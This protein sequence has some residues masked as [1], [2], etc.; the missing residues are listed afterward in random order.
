MGPAL[1][2][3]S[4]YRKPFNVYQCTLPWDFCSVLATNFKN[5]MILS[6]EIL[7]ETILHTDNYGSHEE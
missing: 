3:V 6:L 7:I 5:K 4:P 1:F 2:A